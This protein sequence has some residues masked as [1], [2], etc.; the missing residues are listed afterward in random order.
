MPLEGRKTSSTP[1]NT[2][3]KPYTFYGIGRGTGMITADQ[4]NV[5]GKSS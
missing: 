4:T 5:K 3:E 1:F 2:Y